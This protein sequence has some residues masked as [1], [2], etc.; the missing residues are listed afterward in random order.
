VIRALRAWLPALLWTALIFAFNSR[1]SL[2]VA[3]HSGSDKLAHFAAYSILGLLLA[4][5][6][7]RSA[8]P[9]GWVLVIG[10]IVGALDETYQGFVPG[11]ARELG[12]WVADAAGVVTGVLLYHRFRRSRADSSR[13]SGGANK[14]LFNE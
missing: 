14:P 13:A 1:P 10:M 2:P 4:F 9:L 7:A 3:L 12:D 11:R 6:Q 8:V 5:G